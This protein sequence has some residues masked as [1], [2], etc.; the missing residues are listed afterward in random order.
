MLVEAGSG[1]LGGL[2]AAGK[3]GAALGV[4]A[5]EG[6]LEGPQAGTQRGVVQSGNVEHGPVS[7]AKERGRRPAKRAGESHSARGGNCGRRG[8]W[9]RRRARL[10]HL[11]RVQGTN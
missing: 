5:G 11:N 1:L 6:D 7:F 3:G 8:A 4:L 10:L 2:F 9:C